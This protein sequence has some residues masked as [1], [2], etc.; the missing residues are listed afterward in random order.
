MSSIATMED[1]AIKNMALLTSYIIISILTFATLL[2]RNMYITIPIIIS[3]GII[4]IWRL[5]KIQCESININNITFTADAIF[6]DLIIYFIQFIMFTYAINRRDYMTI[7]WVIMPVTF[8]FFKG[9]SCGIENALN[10]N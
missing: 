7:I 1:V 8:E 4:L 9:I 6:N 10:I 3:D 5:K 2:K